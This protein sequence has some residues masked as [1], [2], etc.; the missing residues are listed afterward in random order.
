MV[1]NLSFGCNFNKSCWTFT[2]S[3]TNTFQRSV[4]ERPTFQQT[5][6]HF[7]FLLNVVFYSFNVVLFLICNFL[8][9]LTVF[10]WSKCEANAALL[11]G[12][13]HCCAQQRSNCVIT[14]TASYINFHS[15]AIKLQ[16]NQANRVVV[17]TIC[18]PGCDVSSTHSE[19]ILAAFQE[20]TAA[21]WKQFFFT[22]WK[23]NWMGL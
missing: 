12:K 4:E 3:N 19:P 7:H 10:S 17:F 13:S 2:R 20:S 23:R 16:I 5:F 15:W 9:L 22:S 21:V 8:P 14:T 11:T 1:D 6:L 18:G